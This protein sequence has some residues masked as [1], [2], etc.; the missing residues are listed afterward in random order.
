[1][2]WG[3]DVLYGSHAETAVAA[4]STTWLFAEGATHGSFDL[5]YLLQNPGDTPATVLKRANAIARFPYLMAT[6]LMWLTFPCP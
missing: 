6:S 4:P 1:M 3:T 5:F 2:Q